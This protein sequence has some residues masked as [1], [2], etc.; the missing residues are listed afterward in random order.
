MKTIISFLLVAF[1][2]T[3]LSF[4]QENESDKIYI[5][6]SPGSNFTIG[7]FGYKSPYNNSS[8]FARGGYLGNLSFSYL[9][10]TH[11]GVTSS[12]RY[13]FNS[14]D[15]QPIVD[16]MASSYPGHSWYLSTTNW[17]MFGF[18][19]GGYASFPISSRGN[20]YSKIM[21]GALNVT[22]PDFYL[23]VDD[24]SLWVDTYGASA[25]A[26]SYLAGIGF[27]LYISKRFYLNYN[28]D[29]LGSNPRFFGV[30]TIDSDGNYS[31]DNFSQSISMINYS[32]GFGVKF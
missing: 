27:N 23:S 22:S 32:I 20:I 5:D 13:G 2:S 6:L 29:F 17:K 31:Y 14:I 10:D 8:G 16:Y 7:E 18:W 26:F 12:F 19:A 24:G 11:F 3:S 25:T 21:F 9:I 4:S 30:E 1:L 28:I 15:G